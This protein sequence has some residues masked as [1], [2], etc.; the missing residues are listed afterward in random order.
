MDVEEAFENCTKSEDEELVVAENETSL[1]ENRAK[2]Y[3][4][5]DIAISCKGDITSSQTELSFG[6]AHHKKADLKLELASKSDS[7]DITS[8]ESFSSFLFW[9]EPL[10]DVDLDAELTPE[11]EKIVNL[12]KSSNLNESELNC[13]SEGGE[14][15]SVTDLHVE[16]LEDGKLDT[17]TGN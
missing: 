12:S 9:R 1:E 8:P 7:T 2:A 5:S 11:S 10:P 6:S 14:Q 16:D 17:S 4:D 13:D 3:Q 15:L